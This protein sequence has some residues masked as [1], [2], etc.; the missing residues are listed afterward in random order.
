MSAFDKLQKYSSGLGKSAEKTTKLV[1]S[2]EDAK[3][4]EYLNSLYDEKSAVGFF[5]KRI[6]QMGY[7]VVEK[8]YKN[9]EGKTLF[10][11][12]YEALPVEERVKYS[13]RFDLT[14]LAKF[15]L[16][17]GDMLA[18]AGAGSGKTTALVFAS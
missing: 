9:F 7:L 4:L 2:S 16:A 17:K 12:D 13:E 3:A 1:E 5:L 11:Q 15:I 18:I 8:V 10:P 14:E 6:H